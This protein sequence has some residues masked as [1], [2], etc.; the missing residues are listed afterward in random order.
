MWIECVKRQII[1]QRDK[2]YIK[3]KWKYDEN[4]HIQN[5]TFNGLNSRK[6]QKT[7]ICKKNPNENKD[8]F[9]GNKTIVIP[10]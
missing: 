4:Y 10:K 2:R 7:L 1:N 8:F 3:A 9:K 5:E 6:D